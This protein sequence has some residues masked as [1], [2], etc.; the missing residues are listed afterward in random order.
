MAD[1]ERDD[2][3]KKFF[4]RTGNFTADD[5]I[6]MILE[7]PVCAKYIAKKIWTFFAYEEPAPELVEQLAGTFRDHHYEIR[8]LMEEILHSAEFYSAKSIRSQI[9]SPIQWY[10]Q[11]A[12][13][14]DVD[15]PPA[16]FA[17][18]SLRSL[19]QMPFL[20]PNVKGW[21]GGKAWI[22]ASTLLMRYNMAAGLAG[23]GD[24][25][26]MRMAE[27]GEPQMAER[28]GSK[29]LDLARLAPPALRADPKAL[30]QALGFR[31]YQTKLTDKE[32][33]IFLKYLDD[34]HGD[35]SDQTIRGLLNLMMSTPEFQ[36]T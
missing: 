16:R 26:M 25:R 2:G 33:G 12:R 18:N 19:G 9:K 17:M 21:D 3:E 15:L 29:S 1:F 36:L 24:A 14:L 35:T 30:V 28:G 5:I 23:G 34:Q 31:L 6:D 11:T 22:N 7:K 8:P 13:E 4:G 32:A 20:P 27:N 10:V